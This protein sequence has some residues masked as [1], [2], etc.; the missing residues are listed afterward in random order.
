M[1]DQLRD[2]GALRWLVRVTQ[3]MN[4][5][6]GGGDG[7]GGG[8]E[9]DVDGGVEPVEVKAEVAAVLAALTNL[10]NGNPANQSRLRGEEG[11]MEALTALVDDPDVDGLNRKAAQKA[12]AALGSVLDATQARQLAKLRTMLEKFPPE[13]QV[14]TWARVEGR[15]WVARKL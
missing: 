1:Q 7:G 3:V 10:A 15:M 13:T 8:G 11:L 12:L 14:A 5:G 2:A 9:V 6:T 4:T